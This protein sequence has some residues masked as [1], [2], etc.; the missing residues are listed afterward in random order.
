MEINTLIGELFL[1]ISKNADKN[2][3]QYKEF[4]GELTKIAN[5]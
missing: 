1:D 2:S 4:L 3:E 5:L